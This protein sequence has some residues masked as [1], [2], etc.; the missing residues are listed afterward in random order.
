MNISTFISS[1]IGLALIMYATFML[2]GVYWSI[3]ALGLW[4]MTGQL[5]NALL[6]AVYKK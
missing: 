4:L 6:E 1:L 2:G 5:V 3:L